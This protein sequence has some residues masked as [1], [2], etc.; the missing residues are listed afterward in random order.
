MTRKV[1]NAKHLYQKW[2]EFAP[3]DVV[4][5]DVP[6][7]V[8]NLHR[9]GVIH[10]LDYTSDKW[11]RG[12]PVY[13]YHHFKKNPPLL[14]TDEEKNYFIDGNIKVT[15]LGIDDWDDSQKHPTVKRPGEAVSKLGILE[16]IAYEDPKT[17][18]ARTVMFGDRYYVGDPDEDYTYI[19]SPMEIPVANPSVRHE[20][21]NVLR[22]HELPLD[23]IYSGHPQH[24]AARKALDAVGLEQHCIEMG[25]HSNP[26]REFFYVIGEPLPHVPNGEGGYRLPDDENYGRLLITNFADTE[27]I[28]TGQ[29]WSW[30]H[31]YCS[32]IGYW[33]MLNFREREKLLSLVDSLWTAEDLSFY[34]SNVW[35]GLR[36]GVQT[37]I[38]NA[39]SDS[40]IE[41]LARGGEFQQCAFLPGE[42]AWWE[43]RVRP[44]RVVSVIDD[45][46]LYYRLAFYSLHYFE[47]SV[48]VSAEELSEFVQF[49]TLA[50]AMGSVEYLAFK[51]SFPPGLRS[52]EIINYNAMLAGFVEQ[53]HLKVGNYYRT[54]L[55]PVA[56]R[57]KEI[58][59]RSSRPYKLTDDRA[60]VTVEALADEVWPIFKVDLNELTYKQRLWVAKFV[61]TYRLGRESAINHRDVPFSSWPPADRALAELM[62]RV[63]PFYSLE[64]PDATW[65]DVGII[66]NASYRGNILGYSSNGRAYVV[67]G[68][69]SWDEPFLFTTDTRAFWV[70]KEVLE[71]LF[72]DDEDDE[73]DE[74]EEEEEPEVEDD[75]EGDEEDSEEVPV[76]VETSPPGGGVRAEQPEECARWS[77]LSAR[78]Q[79][80]ILQLLGYNP[81]HLDIDDRTRR[82]VNAFLRKHPQ[83][84]WEIQSRENP[85]LAVI[86]P[87]SMV[88]LETLATT[89]FEDVVGAVAGGVRVNPAVEEMYVYIDPVENIKAIKSYLAENDK[90]GW[91]TSP[92]RV[93][94]GDPETAEAVGSPVVFARLDPNRLN[95][96]FESSVMALFGFTLNQ[97]GNASM[98]WTVVGQN[99]R[100]RGVG[101]SVLTFRD[102]LLRKMNVPRVYSAVKKGNIVSRNMMARAGYYVYEEGDVVLKVVKQIVDKTSK[103]PPDCGFPLGV[104]KDG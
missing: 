36:P 44:A 73:G 74:E 26:E 95:E 89:L 80:R 60:L 98:S 16:L 4:D 35:E 5:V 96:P 48:Y 30:H 21:H 42:W 24:A 101:L 77:W 13:Y 15:P 62:I 25:G 37:K 97:Y 79:K 90:E 40:I 52:E 22:A 75:E 12:K 72:P 103:V 71:S 102:K 64:R 14:C 8:G 46:D 29:R 43:A 20:I 9:L 63:P 69:S 50:G 41:K 65:R 78:D 55:C 23:A 18:E 57:L 28:A 11:N 53:K 27:G 86:G 2:H 58:D 91:V 84:P 32:V 33:N 76:S 3:S 49:E 6:E 87:M 104:P 56:M 19:T 100:K 81:E 99:Y 1:A 61:R 83:L 59:A 45:G 85:G 94:F 67:A 68:V 38:E 47:V 39:L 93:G 70:P 34:A 88:I 17:H 54:A 7:P 92:S 82:V 10:R 66:G 51:S 31:N